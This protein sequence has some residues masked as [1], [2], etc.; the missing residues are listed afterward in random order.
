MIIV[1]TLTTKTPFPPISE[2]VGKPYRITMTYTVTDDVNLQSV[3]ITPDGASYILGLAPTLWDQ[4]AQHYY[5]E[6]TGNAAQE[7]EINHQ[8]KEVTP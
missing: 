8:F 4:L 3:A 5:D 6:L 1:H 2:V 7:I